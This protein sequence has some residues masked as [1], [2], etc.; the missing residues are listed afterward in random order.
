M[1]STKVQPQGEKSSRANTVPL[2][3]QAGLSRPTTASRTPHTITQ[4]Q[5]QTHSQKHT[6]SRLHISQHNKTSTSKYAQSR[7]IT[8]KRKHKYTTRTQAITQIVIRTHKQT[9]DL[10][11][12]L[13]Q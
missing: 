12:K 7:K 10:S 2:F 3:W 1:K 5:N 9:L 11:S 13:Q 4:A 6:I 8:Y